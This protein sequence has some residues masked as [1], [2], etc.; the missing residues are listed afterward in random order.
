[1]RGRRKEE[2]ERVL[3]LS[4][5]A[6]GSVRHH[7]TLIL[8]SPFCLNQ[9]L[10]ISNIIKSILSLKRIPTTVF[11]QFQSSNMSQI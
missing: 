3:A 8:K 2:R 5:P 6:L 7:C 9:Y 1:M 4:S 10:G 11:Y